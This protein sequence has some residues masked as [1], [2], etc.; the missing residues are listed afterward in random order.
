MMVR[1]H[2]EATVRVPKEAHL[3]EKRKVVKAFIGQM[4]VYVSILAF[5]MIILYR[6]DGGATNYDLIAL[7]TDGTSPLD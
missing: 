2:A 5:V 1:V 3:P 7:Q 4:Q 6:S